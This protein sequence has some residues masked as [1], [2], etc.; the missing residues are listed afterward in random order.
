M[1]N[2]FTHSRKGILL[3]ALFVTMLSF[4]NEGLFYSVDVAGAKTT[5]T[6]SSVQEGSELSIKDSRGAVLYSEMIKVTGRYSRA[7]DLT[8][9]ANGKY[10]FEVE[11]DLEIK[12]IP[13]SMNSGNAF[14]N[15]EKERTIYKPFIRVAG[16]FVY[17]SKLA[18][19]GEPLEIEIYYEGKDTKYKKLIVSEK[20]S[21]EMKIERA[22]KLEGLNF[23]NYKVVLHTADRVFEKSI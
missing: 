1:K 6:L 13:F 22:Y 7:F 15:K 9:L 19:D 20:V 18:V 2:I 4:A 10:R 8:F 14:F 3:V 11:K 16:D 5:F 12:E 21:D 23:G 17:I